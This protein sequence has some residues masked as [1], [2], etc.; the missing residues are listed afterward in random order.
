MSFMFLNFVANCKPWNSNS[1]DIYL[2][3]DAFLSFLEITVR[4]LHACQ[5]TQVPSS[6]YQQAV[7]TTI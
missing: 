4:M 3:I 5:Y 1:I 6:K 7:F 2:M